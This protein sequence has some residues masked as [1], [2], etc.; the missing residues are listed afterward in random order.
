MPSR[1]SATPDV[2]NVVLDANV[3]VPNVLRDTLP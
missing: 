1:T 2:P 3:L